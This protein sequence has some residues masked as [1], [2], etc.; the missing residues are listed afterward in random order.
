MAGIETVAG[1]EIR[2]ARRQIAD[3]AQLFKAASDLRA[4]PHG[5]LQQHCQTR[6]AKSFRGFRHAERERR[7]ALFDRLALIVSRMD[8]QVLRA[9][10][11]GAIQFTAKCGNRFFAD[12]RIERG[13]IHQIIYVNRERRQIVVFANF[14]KAR[15]VL[16]IRNRRAPHSWAGR[17]NLKGVRA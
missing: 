15:D 5:V 10:R 7:H 3:G 9:N 2:F 8:D 11:C 1:R 13:E 16:A 12:H 17:E 14:S 6:R 4:A